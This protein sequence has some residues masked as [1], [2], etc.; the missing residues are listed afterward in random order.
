MPGWITGKK[1]P[2]EGGAGPQGGW[3]TSVLGG[4]RSLAGQLSHFSFS[5]L[6]VLN[7]IPWV[8]PRSLIKMGKTMKVHTGPS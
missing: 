4:A 7:K 3:E 8:N 5:G 2:V 6:I 1:V